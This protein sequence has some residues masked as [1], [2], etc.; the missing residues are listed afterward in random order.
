MRQNEKWNKKTKAYIR[1][2]HFFTVLQMK[3]LSC[4]GVQNP[5]MSKLEFKN[6]FPQ[7]SLSPL[8]LEAIHFFLVVADFRHLC[9]FFR[10][11]NRIF[12][13]IATLVSSKFISANPILFTRSHAKD[14]KDWEYGKKREDILEKMESTLLRNRHRSFIFCLPEA[15]YI[16]MH[17]VCRKT[18]YFRLQQK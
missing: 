15:D 14:R 8:E 7:S 3:L 11:S 4:E 17:F 12:G 9:R 10:V 6:I 5:K 2:I 1:K 18:F 13:A 16:R